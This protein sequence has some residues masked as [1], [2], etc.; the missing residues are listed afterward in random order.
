MSGT[1]QKILY[2]SGLSR[3]CTGQQNQRPSGRSS[4][5]QSFF[6]RS[7]PNQGVRSPQNVRKIKIKKKK[8]KPT[9]IYNDKVMWSRLIL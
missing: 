8:V 9:D 7:T 5:K 1:A 6:E 4:M 2:K 3:P